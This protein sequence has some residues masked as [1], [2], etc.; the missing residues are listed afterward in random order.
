MIEEA[1][2]KLT[3]LM[4]GRVPGLIDTEKT[5]NEKEHE[6]AILLNRLF[7]FVQ[8]IHEFILPLSKGRLDDVRVPLPKNFLASPFK[9]LHSH[10]QHLTWQ[11]KQVAQGDY[12][13]RVDFM[14]DF[15]EAFNFMIAS[16]GNSE[17]MLKRKIEELKKAL[18][19][20]TTLE[21]ILPICANC[22]KIKVEGGDPENQKSW[23]Q[24]E[25]YISIRTRAQFSHSICPSCMGKLYPDLME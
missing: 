15:S 5:I 11:A 7:L 8:E 13:Q 25:N 1:I 23:V 6:L 19:H 20:I 16:L 22:K 24:M 17:E 2:K 9:E 12:T 10:L 4:Q 3:L 21:G 18:S 14:G